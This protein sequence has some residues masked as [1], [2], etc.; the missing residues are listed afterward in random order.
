MECLSTLTELPVLDLVGL[1]ASFIFLCYSSWQDIRKREVTDR[2]WLFSYPAALAILSARLLTQNSSWSLI[3]GSVAAAAIVS[4]ALPLLG[5]WGGADGK[6]FLCLALMNP[7][8]PALDS[9]TSH[10]VNPLF[11][12]VVFSNAYVASVSSV[13]YAI[14]RNLRT[15]PLHEL[16][17]GLE[18][19]RSFRKIAAFLTGYRIPVN[20]LKSKPFIFPLE[21]IHRQGSSISRHFSFE[22]SVDTDVQKELEEIEALTNSGLL[23]GTIWVT[24]GIPFLVFLT[25][26]LVVSLALGDVIWRLVSALLNSVVPIA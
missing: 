26:G 1:A 18:E 15:R 11:P 6:A 3:V 16:F 9:P 14:Q 12:L 2:V 22:M 8:A 25:I 7:I 23:R 21:T 19:E 5:L 17:D 13:L 24:P 20:K 4:L 10:I